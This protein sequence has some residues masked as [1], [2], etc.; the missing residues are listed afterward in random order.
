V[1]GDAYRADEEHA[2]SRLPGDLGAALDALEE[3]VHLVEALGPELVAT[4]LAVKRFEVQR[5]A[6]AVG[7]LDVDHVT[8]WELEEYASHL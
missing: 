6:E 7:D 5:F 3:D 8:E 2:G 4:F 1:V